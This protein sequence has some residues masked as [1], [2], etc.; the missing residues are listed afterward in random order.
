MNSP[1]Q[2]LLD[3]LEEEL[4]R[5]KAKLEGIRV[6]RR[7]LREENYKLQGALKWIRG[8]AGTLDVAVAIADKTLK[9]LDE[10]ESNNEPN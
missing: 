6:D 10:L 9:E 7:R 8:L 3:S 5:T 4:A 2:D 1:L